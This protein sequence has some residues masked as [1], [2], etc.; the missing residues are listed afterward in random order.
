VLITP[1]V[2][3]GCVDGIMRGIIINEASEFLNLKVQELNITEEMLLNSSELFL[4]NSIIG[5]KY[6]LALKQKRYFNVISTQ[7]NS[8][9]NQFFFKKQL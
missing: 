5:V 1:P 3:S 6:V 8:F 9:L 2:S 7:I 4:T